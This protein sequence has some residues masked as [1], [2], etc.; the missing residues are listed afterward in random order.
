MIMKKC[1]TLI[2]FV[3]FFG[4]ISISAGMDDVQVKER[5]VSHFLGDEGMSW[6]EAS[7]FKDRFSVTDEQLYRVLMDIYR[8]ADNQKTT[9]VPKTRE[10][11]DNQR[12]EGC[13]ID[14]LSQCG[15][16]PVKDFLL[17]CIDSNKT[18][19]SNKRTAIRSYLHVADAEEAKDV[20]L[21]FLIGEDRMDDMA[22]SSIY[23]YARTAFKDADASKRAAIFNARCVAAAVES[24]QWDFEDCDSM[25]IDMYP[26]YKDSLLRESMLRR[27][28][29]FPFSKY[30][31]R[32]KDQMENKLKRLEKLRNH[33]DINTNL[34]ALT[35]Y[36]NRPQSVLK[37][38]SSSGHV[39]K[40]V[41]AK[42]NTTKRTSLILGL[43][44]VVALTAATGF[45]W[46]RRKHAA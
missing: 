29:S 28:I 15:D 26:E 20:L 45:W 13:V 14:L 30:H 16:I 5:L 36:Y 33:V 9:L 7:G 11:I 17:D 22:R 39:Q 18:E 25:M 31:L 32:I 24:P 46:Y 21:R 38:D 41:D 4:T 37:K 8:E 35:Q 1:I 40:N 6:M 43:L 19:A 44:T 27:Q 3:F 10:W 2:I 42:T 12:I 34:A 23:R